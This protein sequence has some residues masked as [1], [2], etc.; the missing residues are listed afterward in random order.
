MPASALVTYQQIPMNTQTLPPTNFAFLQP[1]DEQLVRLGLLAEKYFADDPNTCQLKLRQ[2]AELLAQLLAARVGLYTT[3]Q[4]SAE[5][6]TVICLRIS[7]DLQSSSFWGEAVTVSSMK[8]KIWK[9]DV[10]WR[11]KSRIPR[12]VIL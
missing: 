2:F 4:E 7:I 10:V 1:H 5:K 3:A 12:Q 9:S 11:S 6:R 8:R